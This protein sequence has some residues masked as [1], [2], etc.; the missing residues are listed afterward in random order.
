[1]QPRRSSRLAGGASV[2]SEPDTTEG[3]NSDDE[4][5]NSLDLRAPR[6]MRPI[7][8]VIREP[9]SRKRDRVYDEEPAEV[10]IEFNPPFLPPLLA[11]E[12][13]ETEDYVRREIEFGQQIQTKYWY[14]FAT[15]VAGQLDRP[16]DTIMKWPQL[17][18]ATVEDLQAS[19]DMRESFA[20]LV[21]TYIA[22]SSDR[23]R[24]RPG[25]STDATKYGRARLAILMRFRFARF[26]EN[27]RLDLRVYKDNRV[28]DQ[29][30][31]SFYS[32][33]VSQRDPRLQRGPVMP[34]G[35]SSVRLWQP[36]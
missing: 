11:E 1:M 10:S 35:A 36:T 8:N 23:G 26:R 2:K 32:G 27:A 12:R 33:A 4:A 25:L 18:G 14:Q 34:P 20:E 6:R 22:T 16:L 7:R 13:R 17:R 9:D 3:T 31:R 29:E 30:R 28:I 15:L 24:R 5:T 19:L 21:A